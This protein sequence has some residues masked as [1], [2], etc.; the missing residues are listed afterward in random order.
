MEDYTDIY[1]SN[2]D[3]AMYKDS[4]LEL[5]LEDSKLELEDKSD[6]K[7]KVN[8]VFTGYYIDNNSVSTREICIGSRFV[9]NKAKQAA[10][11]ASY[12]LWNRL[13]KM[14]YRCPYEPKYIKVIEKTRFSKNKSYYYKCERKLLEY[15]IIFKLPNR[16]NITYSYRDNIKK[17]N[18]SEYISQK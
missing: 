6:K 2:T 11:K 4:K 1:N 18:E 14:G 7:S 3:F 12:V 8:R 9:G 17:C 16:E 10:C 5:K 15:P 13:K